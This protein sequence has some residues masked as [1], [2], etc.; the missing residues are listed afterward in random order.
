MG[1]GIAPS[2]R[3]WRKEQGGNEKA[4]DPTAGLLEHPKAERKQ[5]GGSGEKK[6]L[7]EGGCDGDEGRPG[8][9]KER[10]EVRGSGR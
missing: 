6:F 4:D 5:H 8:A 3:E 7:S 9:E 10:E 1:A 2:D